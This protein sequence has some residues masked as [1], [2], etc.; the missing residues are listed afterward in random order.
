M[1]K[2]EAILKDHV[3]IYNNEVHSEVSCI[4]DAM[5]AYASQEREKAYEAGYQAAISLSGNEFSQKHNEF[6]NDAL[7]A[8]DKQNPLI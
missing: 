4:T 6:M 5:K 7:E 1:K 2:A 3:N 8:Y